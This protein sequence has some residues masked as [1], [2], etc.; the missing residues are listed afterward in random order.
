MS[1]QIDIITCPQWGA[2]L[3]KQGI[4]TCNKSKEIIFHHTAGHHKEISLPADES[5]EEAMAYARAIQ[6]FH[7]SPRPGYP[8]GWI[9]SGHNFLVCRNGMI[10]QGRW[11]TVSAIQTGHM[12]WSAHCLGKNAQ[13]GIEHEHLG[14]ELMTAVQRESSA[15][16]I[17][18]IAWKYGYKNIMPVY[19]HNKFYNTQCPANLVND[20]PLIKKIASEILAGAY[21]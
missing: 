5:R 11:L 2:K 16:L 19:P 15:R 17:A 1:V 3:P 21:L 14:T 10:L 13:I 6:D 7:M 4:T 20:I 18:W 12:V 8:D 9:D